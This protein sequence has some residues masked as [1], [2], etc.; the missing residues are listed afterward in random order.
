MGELG[1]VR[2]E[3]QDQVTV[4]PMEMFHNDSIMGV[5][6]TKQV[7]KHQPKTM[8]VSANVSH[9]RNIDLMPSYGSGD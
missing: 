7:L 5:Q 3:S 6:R 8:P 1:L 2:S 9:C 4:S